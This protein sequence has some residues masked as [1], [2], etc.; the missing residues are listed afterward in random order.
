MKRIS[1][2]GMRLKSDMMAQMMAY[3]MHKPND[4]MADM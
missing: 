2:F 4:L 1:D 3:R